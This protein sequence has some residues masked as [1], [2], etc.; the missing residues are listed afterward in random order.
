MAG[1][2]VTVIPELNAAQRD[3]I[4]GA[5]AAHGIQAFFFDSEAEAIPCLHDAEIL[6]CHY[7]AL[8]RHAPS[9]RWLC[10]PFA[11]VDPF[12]T[13]GVFCSPDVLLTNSSGAYGVTIAEHI[14]MLALEMLRRQPE[15]SEIVRRRA[16]IRD[17]PIRSIRGSR[18]TLL[19]TGDIGR[20][21]AR[22]LRPFLPQCLTGVNRS[23]IHPEGLFDR[24]LPEPALDTVL[25]ETDILIISLPG[26]PETFHLMDGRRLALLPDQALVINVGRGA[27]VDQAALENALRAGRLLAA[28]DVFER[29]PL[30]P[31]DPLWTCPN[32]LLAPHIAGNMTLPYTV[33]R[34]TALFLEDLENYCA[35]RPLARLVDPA[36]GY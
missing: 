23:G 11:G 22:R 36:R 34:I 9:L 12:L 5:A 7:A 16:W 6:F 31:E 1:K 21:T 17:L 32:L 29:E 14:L 26:T 20:E 4:R 30:P 25:P 28:L 2:L 24:V 19:G 18:I 10:S 15:Y 35:G 13:E 3:R 33:E 8:P 27:V